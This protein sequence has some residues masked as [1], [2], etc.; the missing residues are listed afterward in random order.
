VGGT[1]G[2]GGGVVS[3]TATN[4]QQG[5]NVTGQTSNQSTAY[6]ATKG[7]A[8]A[9]GYTIIYGS[10]AAGSTF[11]NTGVSIGSTTSGTVS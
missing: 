5:G 11:T 2:T 4:A 7:N 3:G 6:N 8:G 9:T 1:G 10:G